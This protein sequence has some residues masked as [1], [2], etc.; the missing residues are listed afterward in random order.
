MTAM[1]PQ[2]CDL[3]LIL[4]LIR[5]ESNFNSKAIS[6]AGA[7]GLMQIMPA[8]WN[9]WAAIA[10]IR[11]A[12]PFNPVHNI[13]IGCLELNRQINNFGKIEL[14]LTAYNWGSGN[15]KKLMSAAQTD[16]LETLKQFNKVV[17][18]IKPMPEEAKEYAMRI[19]RHYNDPE[20]LDMVDDFKRIIE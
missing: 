10:K 2:S 1:K 20:T 12:D 14:A 15:L 17:E 3:L 13:I 9:E 7:K 6:R 16:D 19:F 11:N 5:Q 18:S 4:S 8:T